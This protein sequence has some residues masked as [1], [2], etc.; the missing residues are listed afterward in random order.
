M[1]VVQLDHSLLHLPLIIHVSYYWFTASFHRQGYCVSHDG[2][3]LL[4]VCEF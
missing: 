1:L 2:Q 3:C 4:Y